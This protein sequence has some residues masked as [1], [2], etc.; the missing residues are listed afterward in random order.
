VH[1]TRKADRLTLLGVHRDA[2]SLRLIE[3]LTDDFPGLMAM[4]GQ[5]DFD[6]VARAYIAA[7]PSHHPSVRWFG[8]RLA[9]FMAATPPSLVFGVPRAWQK[10]KDVELGN[11]EVAAATG[12]LAWVIWRPERTT[13][14]HSME[15]DEAHM[16]EAL[17]RGKTFPEMCEAVVPH[18]GQDQ[19]PARAAGLLCGWVEGGM[20]ATFTY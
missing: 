8:L 5:A 4:C 20:I 7:H 16:F 17:A 11:L 2:Y 3:V 9:D 13:H 10:R 14:F 18:V 12:P 1:D 6:H 19:A 15:P